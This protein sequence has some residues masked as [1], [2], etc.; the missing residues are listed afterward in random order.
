[1]DDKLPSISGKKI[2]VGLIEVIRARLFKL[3]VV[4]SIRASSSSFIGSSSKRYLCCISS[5]LMISSS[6]ASSIVLAGS[7]S[8]CSFI[9][10]FLIL[11]L[12]ILLRP[13]EL[14]AES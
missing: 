10:S 1:M 2:V 4:L 8:F 3:A 11:V 5:I 9:D 7:V 12:L 14:L 6:C 13:V